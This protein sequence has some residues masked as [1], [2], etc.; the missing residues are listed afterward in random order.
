MPRSLQ[1]HAYRD[2]REPRLTWRVVG[3]TL[4]ETIALLAML[5]AAVVVVPFLAVML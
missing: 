2:R 4:G 5:F 3:T 1:W